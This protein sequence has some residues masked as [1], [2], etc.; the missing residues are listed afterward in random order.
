M[1]K[2]FKFL[3]PAVLLVSVLFA[4][5]ACKG[6]D[7]P[8]KSNE[9][10]GYTFNVRYDAGNG[11]FTTNTSVVVDSYNPDDFPSGSLPLVAPENKSPNDTFGTLFIISTPPTKATRT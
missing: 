5:T 7:N 11:S 2:I 3:V 8:Y 4:L 10:D 9:D 1:N 6:R